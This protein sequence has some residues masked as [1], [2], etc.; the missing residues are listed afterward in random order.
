M[1]VFSKPTL[2]IK[3]LATAFFN[4]LSIAVIFPLFHTSCDVGEHDYVYTIINNDPIHSPIVVH[5]QTLKDTAKCD[6]L[7]EGASLKIAQRLAVPSDDVWDVETSI[8]MY[9]INTLT[10]VSFDSLS[11]SEE[12][13]FR[14]YWVGPENENGVGHYNLI[15]DESLLPL[16]LQRNYTYSVISHLPDSLRITANFH[17]QILKFDT[18]VVGPQ[19]LVIGHNDIFSFQ[20]DA[21]TDDKYEAKYK[22]QKISGLRS[23]TI[24]HK[25]QYRNVN[26]TKD[27]SLFKITADTCFLIV[28]ENL[29]Q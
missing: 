16:F 1:T 7:C 26:L 2:S 18:T 4:L 13:N 15:V 28:D 17:N 20:E 27:T 3:K 10:I 21:A 29:F 25:Q 8:S 22:I 19:N 23:L 11:K 6:T 12:L 9:K 24:R 5:Y 14:K